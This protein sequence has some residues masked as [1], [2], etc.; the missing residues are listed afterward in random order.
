RKEMN[1]KGLAI[2]NN[3]SVLVS[4]IVGVSM[5]FGGFGVWSLVAQQIVRDLVVC[6]MYWRLSSWRPRFLF[7]WKHLRDLMNLSVW[8]FVAQLGLFAESQASSIL[9]GLFFGPVAVGLYRLAD[10]VIGSVLSMT[11]A[12]IQSVSLP[13]F[14]RLQNNPSELRRSILSC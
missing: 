14:S 10:R 12:S 9:L 4:G 2:C 1:F 7:S 5:A 3:V 8:N 6:V 11:T 13:E